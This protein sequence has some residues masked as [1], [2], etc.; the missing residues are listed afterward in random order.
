MDIYWVYI[1]IL[2]LKPFR[3]INDKEV[4]SMIRVHETSRSNFSVSD[5]S[6]KWNDLWIQSMF[7]QVWKCCPFVHQHKMNS[8]C[9]P[10]MIHLDTKES[11]VREYSFCRTNLYITIWCG[12][13]CNFPHVLNIVDGPMG[14]IMSKGGGLLRDELP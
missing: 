5:D 10:K 9:N 12:Q 7:T 11:S 6:W 4:Y 14:I 13:T 2:C 3:M 1:H 8:S